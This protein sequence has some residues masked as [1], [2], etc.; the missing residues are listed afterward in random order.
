MGSRLGDLGARHSKLG[1]NGCLE[2]GDGVGE[3]HQLR[4]L[5]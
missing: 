3:L 1:L 2:V 4:P 5:I